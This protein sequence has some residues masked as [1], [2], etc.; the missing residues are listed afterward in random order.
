MRSILA[1]TL[2]VTLALCSP[3]LAADPTSIE[4]PD[5]FRA[6][7][8]AAITGSG[9]INAAKMIAEAAGQPTQI[10]TLKNALQIFDGK[11]FDF[12]RK[13][14]DNEINSALRQIVYYSYVKD[15]GFIYF[16]LNFKMTSKGWIMAHFTFKTETNELF[17][18]DF[19]DQR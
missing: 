1:M 12:S 2:A 7:I 10:D 17:P 11:K 18:K 9:S 19:V 16:R 14:I 5:K 15:L 6:D 3:G 13:V 8:I 4:N